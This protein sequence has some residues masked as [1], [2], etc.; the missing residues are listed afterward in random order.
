MLLSM[1]GHERSMQRA[2]HG[3]DGH[4]VHVATRLASRPRVIADDQRCEH[5]CGP[6]SLASARMPESETDA[7]MIC[8]ASTSL[9]SKYKLTVE[10]YV[11]CRV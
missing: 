4:V 10:C 9:Y 7:K 6:S 8:H 1:I 5:A 2:H 3:R 11:C